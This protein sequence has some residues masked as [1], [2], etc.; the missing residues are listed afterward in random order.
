MIKCH[1]GINQAQMQCGKAHVSLGI[2][3]KVGNPGVEDD[4]FHGNLKFSNASKF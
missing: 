4:L 3:L 1:S 2:M